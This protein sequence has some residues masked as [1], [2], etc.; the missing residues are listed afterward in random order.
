M[1]GGIKTLRGRSQEIY[2][3]VFDA[4]QQAEEIDGVE[5]VEYVNLMSDIVNEALHRMAYVAITE[6]DR[7]G[8][9][10]E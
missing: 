10:D 3:D 1:M 8:K 5:G 9:Q 4:M 7:R 2:N 6:L